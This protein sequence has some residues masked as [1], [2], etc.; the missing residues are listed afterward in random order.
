MVQ[1]ICLPSKHQVPAD[2]C[3]DG[4]KGE[5]CTL[6]ISSFLRKGLFQ[7]AQ[8]F[9]LPLTGKNLGTSS[10]LTSVFPVKL[11][12]YLSFS[13]KCPPKTFKFNICKRW[14][15]L[16]FF[17]CAA[18]VSAHLP[19]SPL[20]IPHLDE[21]RL[22]RFTSWDENACR[23]AGIQLGTKRWRFYVLHTSG[24]PLLAFLTPPIWLNCYS[25]LN[26]SMAL[27]LGPA[28]IPFPCPEEFL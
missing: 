16:T 24:H 6:G 19:I 18:E 17:V 15:H 27:S 9:P 25:L 3:S 22:H 2:Q 10:T 20:F 11:I 23:T 1:S 4:E 8:H 14:N 28:S 21:W 7:K 5:G 26:W 12:A 13:L